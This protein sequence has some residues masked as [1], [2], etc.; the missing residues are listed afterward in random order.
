MSIPGLLRAVRRHYGGDPEMIRDIL[1][2][3]IRRSAGR[4]FN[5]GATPAQAVGEALSELR[6]IGPLTETDTALVLR[7]ATDE[8]RAFQRGARWPS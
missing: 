2:V 7:I 3:E 8:W 5:R 6:Q 4:A 1:M